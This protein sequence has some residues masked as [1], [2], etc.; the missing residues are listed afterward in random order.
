MKRGR[1]RP[2]AADVL[3]HAVGH[4][5][6][7]VRG[8]RRVGLLNPSNPN[9]FTA[10]VAADA[11]AQTIN[12]ESVTLEPCGERRGPDRASSS[13]ARASTNQL[14]AS[15]T[16]NPS[17]AFYADGSP[18]AGVP[19]S[20]YSIRWSGFI[21]PPMTGTYQFCMV[22]DTNAQLLLGG[23]QLRSTTGSPLDSGFAPRQAR[24]R[25]RRFRSS[26]TTNTGWAP[27]TS[28]CRGSRRAVPRRRRD[29]H[30]RA[31]IDSRLRPRRRSADGHR[32]PPTGACR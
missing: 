29:S 25:A 5:V 17:D 14:V 20:N 3:Q 11:N 9:Q 15:A 16:Q 22:V 4:R 12:A 26:W 30:E 1:Q 32:R 6:A 8:R 28:S 13:R 23:L 19:A 24:P 27:A 18:A 21:T 31:V 2:A 10:G 7:R